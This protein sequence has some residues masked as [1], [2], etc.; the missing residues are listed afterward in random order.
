MLRASS[1]I[2]SQEHGGSRRRAPLPQSVVDGKVEALLASLQRQP[3]GLGADRLQEG[4]AAPP[5]E[6]MPHAAEAWL[7][8]GAL[9]SQLPPFFQ[10]VICE[11]LS[12]PG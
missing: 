1:S 10:W 11:S 7:G 5:P 12:D 4:L 9:W 3:R 6:C 2:C 8:S